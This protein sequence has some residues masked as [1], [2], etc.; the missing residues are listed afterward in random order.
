MSVTII[1]AILLTA[2]LGPTDSVPTSSPIPFPSPIPLPPVEQRIEATV[3]S[4]CI[5]AQSR[6]SQAETSSWN[7]STNSD[8]VPDWVAYI[9]FAVRC[10]LNERGLTQARIYADAV[11]SIGNILYQMPDT[12]GSA[13]WRQL[14]RQLIS[15]ALPNASSDRELVK[16]LNTLQKE[17]SGGRAADLKPSADAVAPG[18]LAPTG[19]TKTGSTQIPLGKTEHETEIWFSLGSSLIATDNK[20]RTNLRSLGWYICPPE[21]PNAPHDEITVKIIRP[22]PTP[23]PHMPHRA[24]RYFYASLRNEWDV[25][26]ELYANGANTTNG[27]FL[28]NAVDSGPL[29][30]PSKT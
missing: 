2:F 30:A 5:T 19:A 21:N 28:V 24:D 7:A 27:V 10:G 16:L 26:V 13:K 6:R 3:N 14:S 1:F 9:D 23:D 25:T 18:R 17:V 4:H 11:L 8:F 29:C 12:Y 20:V 22:S 15:K